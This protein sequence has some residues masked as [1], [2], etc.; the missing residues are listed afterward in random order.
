MSLS[1]RG[2]GITLYRIPR[3]LRYSL[4]T[5]LAIAALA[6]AL[7]ASAALDS[8][9]VRAAVNGA[10]H[11]Q[12]EDSLPPPAYTG[13]PMSSA[14]QASITA[15]GT[16][17]LDN[18]FAG[19]ELAARLGTLQDNIKQQASG[20]TLYLGAGVTGIEISDVQINGD[21]ATATATADVWATFGQVQDG[22]KIVTATPTNSMNYSFT[23]SRINGTWYVV[24]E[25]ITFAPGSEP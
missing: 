5:A 23:L 24:H 13:G 22:G 4:A 7:T 8:N 9:A 12:Q 21:D 14:I 1:N 6:V 2:F 25:R 18:Y 19:P 20:E 3:W 10:I 17:D 16:K 15:E 11:A